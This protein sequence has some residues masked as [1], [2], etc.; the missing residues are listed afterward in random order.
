MNDIGVYKIKTFNF[1]LQ[2]L[3]DQLVI[4]FSDLENLPVHFQVFALHEKISSDVGLT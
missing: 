3:E 1:N 2:L 4:S